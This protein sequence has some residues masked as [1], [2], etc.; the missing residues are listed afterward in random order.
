MLRPLVEN[1]IYKGIEPPSRL[2][3]ISLGSRNKYLNNLYSFLFCIDSGDF[4]FRSIGD[5]LASTDVR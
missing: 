3:H 4:D 5:F 1:T 2:S